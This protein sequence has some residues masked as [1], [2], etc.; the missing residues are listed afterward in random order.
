MFLLGVYLYNE[1]L[2]NAQ[3]L[4]FVLIWAALFIYSTDSAMYYRLSKNLRNPNIL[5]KASPKYSPK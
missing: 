5:A 1:P 4:T 3:I 2:L